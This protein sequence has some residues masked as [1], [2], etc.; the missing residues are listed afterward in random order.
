M[1]PA[2]LSGAAL[3]LGLLPRC[4]GVRVVAG[5]CIQFASGNG[6]IMTQSDGD[7]LPGTPASVVDAGSP[8]RLVVG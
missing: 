2:L 1:F 6:P 5:A 7:A 4:P 8:I 3:P